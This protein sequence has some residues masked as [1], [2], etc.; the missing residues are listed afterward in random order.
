[1]KR[2]GQL[3]LAGVVILA[4]TLIALLST[5]SLQPKV[6]YERGH[7]QAAQLVYLARACMAA[8]GCNYSALLANLKRLNETYPMRMYE[9]SEVHVLSSV[10]SED[11][12]IVVANSTV[13]EIR[14][15]R[16]VF[17][18]APEQVAVEVRTVCEETGRKY[19]KQV[20][21]RVYALV[22]VKVAYEHTYTSPFF[23]VKLCPT[24]RSPDS[25]ADLKQ[26]ER[27]KW[28]VGVP[29]E[30]SEAVNASLSPG[31]GVKGYCYTLKDDFGIPVLVMFRG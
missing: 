31:Q 9:V 19:F 15:L 10:S 5:R 28:L 30:L 14:T 11:G 29:L 27:C 24:L 13:F 25:V 7:L 23:N 16:S 26:L 20:G 18:G 1:M 21:E 17:I 2:R 8:G 12:A 3:A 6:A 22:E 4:L